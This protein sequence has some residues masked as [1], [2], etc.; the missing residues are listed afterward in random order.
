MK[1]DKIFLEVLNRDIPLK[2]KIRANHSSFV[3]NMLRK[4]IMR[5]S[6][7]EKKYLKKRTDQS[8][9][10]YKKQK[11]YC[12]KLYKKEKKILNGLTNYF[13]KPLFN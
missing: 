3:S 4:A 13:A 5:K 8:L 7:L 9:M 2:K 1:L 10:A 11:N 12:I 6:Y